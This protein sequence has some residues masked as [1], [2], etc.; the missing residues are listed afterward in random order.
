MSNEIS[1]YK[2]DIAIA[3]ETPSLVDI[4][5]D[6]RRFPRVRS[7]PYRDAHIQMKGIVVAAHLRRRQQASDD[8][9][10]LMAGEVLKY[11]LKDTELQ[12]YTMHDIAMA[13]EE[14]QMYGDLQYL[15]AQS[16]FQSLVKFKAKVMEAKQQADARKRKE[17][18]KD[19]MGLDAIQKA[20]AAMMLRAV[21]E[22][23]SNNQ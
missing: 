1:Q 18:E 22:R 8:E 20:Y 11:I 3:S 23:N 12:W 2:A 5:S 17:Q 16:I 9:Y 10:G 14:D 15:S 19:R 21:E 13:I 4:R 7:L 6:P